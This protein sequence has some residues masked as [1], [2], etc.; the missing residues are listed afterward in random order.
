MTVLMFKTICTIC[1][2]GVTRKEE[3]KIYKTQYTLSDGQRM[4]PVQNSVAALIK[5][6]KKKSRDMHAT[7]LNI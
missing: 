5:H 4:K 6:D 3:F 1:K 2:R 7:I